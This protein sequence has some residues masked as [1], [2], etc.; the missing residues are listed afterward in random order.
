M[1]RSGGGSM[2]VSIRLDAE[3]I[4]VTVEYGIQKRKEHLAQMLMIAVTIPVHMVLKGT[5][6]IRPKPMGTYKPQYDVD[7]ETNRSAIAESSWKRIKT[8][9][10]ISKY[11]CI[12]LAGLTFEHELWQ[13]G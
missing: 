7:T 2:Y 12:V 10:V 5:F 3:A 13:Y 6:L 9:K 8:L 4:Y 1:Q 11:V